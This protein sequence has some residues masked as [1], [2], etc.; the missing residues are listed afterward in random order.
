MSGWVGQTRRPVRPSRPSPGHKPGVL[1]VRSARR[2]DDMVMI[3]PLRA[4]LPGP[5][6]RRWTGLGF[7]YWLAAMTALEPGNVMNAMRLGAELHWARETVR[8]VAAG[9]LG[10]AATP[11]L[12]VLAQRF[13]VERRDSLAPL[14]IQVFA[15]LVLA[16]VLIV[17][18]CFLAAWM[19]QGR[20]A[21]R[22]AEVRGEFAANL[23]LVTLCLSLFLGLIQVAQRL[24]KPPEKAD[25]ARPSQL[26]IKDRGRL[27]I[28]DLGEIEWIETQG[29]YQALHVGERVHLLRETSARLSAR[30][31]PERFAR[32]HRRTIVALAKVREI[33]PL[34]NGD[35]IVRLAGGAELRASRSHRAA[36]RERLGGMA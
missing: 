16:G 8:L 28:V 2:L 26:A 31:D 18:S 4:A 25:A 21:P 15:V 3:S 10:A 27:T 6:V 29:N 22:M 19:F 12:L 23:L 32:I 13:P 11:L 36:L 17:I 33:E 14:A 20:P 9:L 30:L 7:L 35:A 1:D 24:S 34:P 5:S